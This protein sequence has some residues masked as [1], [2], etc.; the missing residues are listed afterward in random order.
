MNIFSY[1]IYRDYIA[2]RAKDEWGAITRLAKAAGC[3]RSYLSRA[4]RGDV[5]LTPDHL[6]GLCEY[7]Q[8]PDAER[9]YLH[10]LLEKARAANPSYR[11]HLERKQRN[12]LREQEN[13]AKRLETPRLSVGERELY[14]YS[15]WHWAALHIA[16]SVPSLQTE[17]ALAQGLHLPLA[18]VKQ[19]LGQL[20]EWGL[21]RKSGSRW[22]HA[23]GNLHLPK[24][25]PL[26]GQSHQLWRQRAI[27]DSLLPGSDGLHYTQLQSMDEA[28]FREIKGVLLASIDRSLALADGAKSEKVVAVTIDAFSIA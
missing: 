28:A 22:V 8:L 6:H 17:T 1:T 25:S 16:T 11:A 15:A 26:I 13:L 21:V 12:I 2:A 7:W 23:S 10:L 20:S 9:E 18:L 3:Q 19:T 14:Y 5:L 27:A 4:I 24:H